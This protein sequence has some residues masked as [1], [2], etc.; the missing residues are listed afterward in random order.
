MLATRPVTR[1]A[2]PPARLQGPDM[3]ER[4]MM[5]A[6]LPDS[7]VVDGIVPAAGRLAATPDRCRGP[8]V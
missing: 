5:P 7:A 4:W 8:G 1:P 2:T 6:D 3:D